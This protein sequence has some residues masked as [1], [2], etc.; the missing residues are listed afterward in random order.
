MTPQLSND[1]FYYK[2]KPQEIASS[3]I[4]VILTYFENRLI[5]IMKLQHESSE[6][7]FF[8]INFYHKLFTPR[9]STLWQTFE[10]GVVKSMNL[11]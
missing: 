4:H 6:F 5:K 7:E 11:F 10:K 8:H 9:I 3:N 2:Y 1:T